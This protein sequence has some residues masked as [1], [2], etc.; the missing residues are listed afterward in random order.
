MEDQKDV[1]IARL[2][3]ELEKMRA[4]PCWYWLDDDPE[5]TGSGP[6]EVMDAADIYVCDEVVK[7]GVG[8]QISSVWAV[9][10]AT[11]WTD[12]GD[13]DDTEIHVFEDE[14]SAIAAVGKTLLP[15]RVEIGMVLECEYDAP[16]TSYANIYVAYRGAEVGLGG[17]FIGPGDSLTPYDGTE[18]WGG[19]A[20]PDVLTDLIPGTIEVYSEEWWEIANKLMRDLRAAARQMLDA[21]L[22]E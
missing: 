8:K 22:D 12:D 9:R 13:P 17:W 2:L 6:D 7:I 1:E 11:S 15:V 14:A 20:P 10:I 4:G 21:A 19:G 5:Y 16:A 18:N 3:A